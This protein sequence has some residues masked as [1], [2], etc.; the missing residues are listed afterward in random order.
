VLIVSLRLDDCQQVFVSVKKRLKVEWFT[1][2]FCFDRQY[3]IGH[4]AA[5]ALFLNAMSGGFLF[6][7]MLEPKLEVTAVTIPIE[8]WNRNDIS[9]L[10]KCLLAE[11]HACGGHRGQCFAGN[12]W[13]AKTMGMTPGSVMT[14]ISKFRKLSLVLDEGTHKSRLLRTLFCSLAITKEQQPSLAITEPSSVYTKPSLAITELHI[15]R[16]LEIRNIEGVTAEQIYSEYPRKVG[17]PDALKAIKRAMLKFEP[18]RLLEVTKHYATVRKGEDFTPNPSTWYNQE[19]F[20]DD[21]STWKNQNKNGNVE[22]RPVGGN[23]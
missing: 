21:P 20:N 12:D 17:K 10:E 23:F 3:C 9:W 15:E 2:T 14:S 18:S 11:I 4:P 5:L 22:N 19:R 7:F 16:E 1:G 6:S 13:L 8:V